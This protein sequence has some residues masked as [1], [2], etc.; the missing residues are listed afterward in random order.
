MGVFTMAEL[1]S[2]Q[3]LEE[4][5]RQLSGSPAVN[6]N[7]LVS[8][9]KFADRGD[10]CGRTCAETLLQISFLAGSN[11]LVDGDTALAHPVPQSLAN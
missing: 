1:E 2:L 5:F 9:A 7:V 4:S 11:N 6:L 10:D 3:F 8:V